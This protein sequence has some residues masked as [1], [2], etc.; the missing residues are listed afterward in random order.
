MTEE[1]DEKKLPFHEM[2]LDDRILKAIAKLGWIEPTLIQERGIPLVLE[3]KDL[4]ARGRTGSG[5]TGAFA[6]PL[7]QRLLDLKSSGTLQCVRAVVLCPSRELASQTTKVINDLTNSCGGIIRCVDI[8]AKDVSAVKPLLKDLPDVLVGTPGRLAT[9]IKEGNLDLSSSLQMLVI[10]EADLIFSFGFEADL[11]FLLGKFPSIYQAILTSATLSEDVDRLKKLVLHNPV[12]LRLSE[13]DLPDSSQLTQYVI[14]LEEVDKVIL[15]FA[16]FKLELIRGKTLVFV[17]SVDRCYK[18]KLYLEQFSIP[19]CVLNSE[20]PVATRCHT[21]NQ[22][23]KGVY[24]VIVAADEK[25]LDDNVKKEHHK[26]DKDKE[27]GEKNRSK[28]KESGVSRGIDFQYVAN[29]IN[30]DFPGSV[31]SYIHR[32]GRTARGNQQGT[33]LSLVSSQENELLEA[34]EDR[35]QEINPGQINLKPYQFKM[36]ELDGFKYRARDAWRSVTKIAVR[37][38]RLKEIKQEI[39]NSTKLKSFFED[40]PRDQQ[41][42]RHDKALHVVKRH[43]HFKNVPDYIVPETLKKFT[44]NAKRRNKK[45]KSMGPRPTDAQKKFEKRQADPLDMGISKRRKN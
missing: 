26:V 45:N 5:K 2:G 8:G 27:R 14:K 16:L 11:R 18:I 20:L 30:F 35:L 32:V 7:V 42:L 25:L 41:M 36:E 21:V 29:V 3:G 13:P 9:H 43:D 4:L 39:L 22:F 19:C 38:A 40:N 15:I 1:E 24:S 17:S 37:E 6:V 31:D 23:N 10:D 34:V 12:V 28:D 33:A 44:G